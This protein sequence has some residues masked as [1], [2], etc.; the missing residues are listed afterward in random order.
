MVATQRR[1]SRD[2][3]LMASW[4]LVIGRGWDG[5]PQLLGIWDMRSYV[6]PN[7]GTKRL[8]VLIFLEDKYMSLAMMPLNQTRRARLAKA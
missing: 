1:L 3:F 4:K 6:P 7:R 5:E 2:P 8:G